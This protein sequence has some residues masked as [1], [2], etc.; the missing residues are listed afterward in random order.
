V[1]VASIRRL[2][3]HPTVPAYVAVAACAATVAATA[4]GRSLPVLVWVLL[5]ITA[6]YSIS[7]SV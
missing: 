6:G 4:A 3:H 7:G 2:V 5:G 1:T